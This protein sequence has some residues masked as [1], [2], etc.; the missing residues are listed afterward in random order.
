MQKDIDALATH[1][2]VHCLTSGR[3]ISICWR[4]CSAHATIASKV[5]LCTVR[6]A[7]CATELQCCCGWS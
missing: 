7:A 2:A 1:D 4:A 6:A 3:R 5:R